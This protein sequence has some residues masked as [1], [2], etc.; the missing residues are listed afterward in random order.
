DDEIASLKRTKADLSH[1]HTMS[2]VTDLSAELE[3]YA[4]KTELNNISVDTSH[5]ATK[6]SVNELSEQI[7]TKADQSHRH[8]IT[9]VSGLHG[10]LNNKLNS[11]ASARSAQKLT[12]PR[13]ING[14]AFDGTQDITL[15]TPT[16]NV[17]WSAISNK[18]ANFTPSAHRHAIGDI[19]NL[20]RELDNKAS[21]NHSHTWNSIT[22]K[23]AN[24]T[25]SA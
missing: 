25:P 23:P 16:A 13:R 24:F 12:T 21:R 1:T 3:R 5:L 19:T 10:I 9:E 17:S 14:I 7:A 18:P 4:L 20:Q 22:N 8:T 2:E 15:P 11:N 6:S